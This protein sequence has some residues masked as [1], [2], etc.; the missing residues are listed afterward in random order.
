MHGTLGFL[1]SEFGVCIFGVSVCDCPKSCHS[2]AGSARVGKII[3]SSAAQHLTPLT[4][5]LG[6]KCPCYVDKC[7]NFQNAANRIVWAKFLNAGQTC[8]APDYMLCTIETQERMMPCLRQAI[9]EFYGC[10]PQDSPDFGRMINDKHFQRARAL[11]ECGRVA[12]G[13]E[14]DECT[15][16]IG[17]QVIWCWGTIGVRGKQGLPAACH[18]EG[19]QCIA[20]PYG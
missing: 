11:L 5:E 10:N 12:I 19:M 1:G 20:F 9:R 16:Y 6:G 4:M 15:R 13:G 17:E 7:C 14:T 2:S 3:M 18:G 8:I